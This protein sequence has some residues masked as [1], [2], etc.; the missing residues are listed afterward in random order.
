MSDSKTSDAVTP[1]RIFQLGW[2]FVP[3]LMLHAA[4]QNHIFDALDAAPKNVD[5]LVAATGASKRGLKAIVNSFVGFGLIQRHGDRYALAPDAAMFMV[6]TK[7]AFLGGMIEH[8]ANQLLDNFRHLPEIVRTGKP[9]TAVNQ[10][11]QGAE[12]FS[13]FVECLFNLN[14]APACALADELAKQLPSEKINILDIAAGSGVW[15]FGLAQRF[16][17]SQVTAVDWPTVL[18]VT[19]RIAQ[20]QNLADRLHTIEGDIHDVDFGKGFHVATLG[21]ILHSE[22]EK[23]S[24]HLL[25]KVFDALVP[26]GIIAIAEFVPN[27]D[28]TGPSYPLL[29]AVNMLVHT[30]DG[31]TYTFKQMTGWLEEI[32]FRQARQIE[33]PAPSPILIAVKP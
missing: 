18:P 22:G 8:L 10:Q 30:D 25:R 33:V 4:V 15:G 31:D 1:E 5:E 19:R 32:G 14:Y 21:H 26:G 3:T 13:K 28:R 12:F 29:F 23:R 20:R 16:L 11:N 9:S 17:Q 7:P 6:S 27:D 2:G 24:R